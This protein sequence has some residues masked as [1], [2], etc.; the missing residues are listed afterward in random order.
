MAKEE[1]QKKTVNN[2]EGEKGAKGKG[3]K[4]EKKVEELVKKHQNQ[5]LSQSQNLS[6]F[7]VR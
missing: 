2:E 5:N 3:K 7:K 1:E 4:N 6:A